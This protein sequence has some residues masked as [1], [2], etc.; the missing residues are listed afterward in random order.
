MGM[1]PKQY[2]DLQLAEIQAA[3]CREAKGCYILPPGTS[4]VAQ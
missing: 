2:L 1:S 3:A 4:V